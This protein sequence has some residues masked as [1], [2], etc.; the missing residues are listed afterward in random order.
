LIVWV[1][2]VAST[3]GVLLSSVPVYS[4][5]TRRHLMVQEVERHEPEPP[6]GLGDFDSEAS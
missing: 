1:I 3:F 2:A 6:A 4:T 5:S